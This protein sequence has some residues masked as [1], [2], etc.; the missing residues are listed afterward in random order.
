MKLLYSPTSPYS[1]KVR[2][3]AHY[4]DIELE[5]IVVNTSEDPS[6]LIT[7]NPLGKIPTLVTD[8]GQAIFDSRAIMH[9]LHRSAKA[10]LYPKKDE[11]RTEAEVLEALC[12]GTNDS[13]LAI[14]YEKRF[15]PPE[16]VSQ[17]AIDRQWSKVERSLD[18]LNANMP[19]FGKTLHGGHFALASMLGYLMLRFPG[20]WE[21]DRTRLAAWPAKFSERFDAYGKLRPQT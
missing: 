6:E 17:A 18:Y 20:E 9:F 4:L 7:A 13:L 8:D 10:R 3:A 12:D 21:N 11:G 5:G 2:M 1:A 15:R 14:V 16:L 19:K